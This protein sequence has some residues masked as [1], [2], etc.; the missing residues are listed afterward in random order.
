MKPIVTDPIS[1]K[2]AGLNFGKIAG[3]VSTGASKFNPLGLIAGALGVGG[4][5]I[6]T[7]MSNRANTRLVQQQNQNNL[8]LWHEQMAYN[9][10]S[11]Q[12]ARFKA[13]GLNPALMY[14]SM[15]DAG[16]ADVAPTMQA[17][18][19]N[20][21]QVDPLTLAQIA[22]LN[23]QTRSLE[24]QTDREDEKQPLSLE[25][26]RLTNKQIKVV[27][28]KFA[29]EA[30]NLYNQVKYREKDFKLACRQFEWNKYISDEQLK[31][32]AREVG[33]Q[34]ENL[35]AYLELLPYMK[36]EANARINELGKRAALLEKQKE[37]VEKDNELK[38]INLEM[39]RIFQ[40]VIRENEDAIKIMK[41][42]EFLAE[43]A[44]N[45]RAMAEDARQAELAELPFLYWA[46]TILSGPVS[47]IAG[48]GFSVT[49][50]IK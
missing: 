20:A 39:E 29:A 4:N 11:A 34:E 17:A 5:I 3:K 44:K 23:A 18:H 1:S 36:K 48:A 24:H 27:N 26:M 28:D 38:E 50:L 33:V 19:Q 16:N 49:K 8:N 15:S 2:L 13:A 46:Y 30:A 31:L 7:V 12:V 47:S 25:N 43:V 9:T 41:E 32:Q 21:P 6:S 45:R 37:G 40:K 35:K 10:P 14:G 42:N 22:N